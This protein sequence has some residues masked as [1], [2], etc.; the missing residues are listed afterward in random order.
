MK[1]IV[2]S[3]GGYKNLCSQIRRFKSANDQVH[4]FLKYNKYYRYDRGGKNS[5]NYKI[6]YDLK[7][8]GV[9]KITLLTPHSNE[10]I[11]QYH[12]LFGENL[13][14]IE[15]DNIAAQYIKTH[16][17]GNYAV[18]APDGGEKYNDR[19][20]IR[21]KQIAVKLFPKNPQDKIFYITKTRMKKGAIFSNN[22]RGEVL[23]KDVIII[24][25]I[26]DTGSTAIAAAKLLKSHGANRVFLMATHGVFSNG[27]DPLFNSGL[28]E[29]IIVS[30]SIP[31]KDNRIEI[32]S[33]D[34]LLPD[35]FESM[36]FAEEV[37][38]YIA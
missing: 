7:R 4:L 17:S 24:D 11:K 1:N 34:D 33:L 12:S 27:T 18:G 5:P 30:D 38:E 9:D 31:S 20:Q 10:V 13:E 23:G 19:A 36:T 16:F 6:A 25:D 26:I 28:F 35:G 22:F 2:A 32:L 15:P 14:V 21:V 3:I 37:A 29:K 8:S